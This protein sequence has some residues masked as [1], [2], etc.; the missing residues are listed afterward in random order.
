VVNLKGTFF[1]WG[2]ISNKATKDVN[3]L[4]METKDLCRELTSAASYLNMM[5]NAVSITL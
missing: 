5:Y 2:R 3:S 1:L 4:S